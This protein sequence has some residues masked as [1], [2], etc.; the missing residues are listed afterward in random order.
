MLVSI[1]VRT[2]P[3]L[4]LRSFDR[5][6]R[7]QKFRQVQELNDKLCFPPVIDDW[8]ARHRQIHWDHAQ[9]ALGRKTLFKHLI[10]GD[11]SYIKK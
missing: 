5:V 9:F 1:P 11:Q 4:L 7:V 2:L 10:H 8:K 6:A 3:Q